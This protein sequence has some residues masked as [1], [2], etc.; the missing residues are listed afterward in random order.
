M[1]LTYNIS[2]LRRCLIETCRYFLQFR[3]L[4]KHRVLR[5]DG[6][7]L[8]RTQRTVSRES[9]VVLLA[10]IVQRL[11]H[12]VSMTL[13]LSNEYSGSIQSKYKLYFEWNLANCLLVSWPAWCGNYPKY[14]GS[15]SYWSWTDRWPL[16]VLDQLPSPVPSTERIFWSSFLCR[17]INQYLQLLVLTFHVWTMSTFSSMTLSL[18]SFGKLLL[19]SMDKSFN[20]QQRRKCQY[21]FI[22]AIKSKSNRF[23]ICLS[24]HTDKLEM[25]RI[26]D[27]IQINVFCLQTF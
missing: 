5:P 12:K 24:N 3:L 20:D 11:L 1:S 18:E 22:V 4:K 25:S 14:F 19:S 8:R 15:A 10:E 17:K 6:L 13:H 16:R 23:W 9:D 26:V 27:Q 7:S 21:L 2:Y